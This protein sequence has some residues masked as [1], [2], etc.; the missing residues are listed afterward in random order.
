MVELLLLLIYIINI[1]HLGS[2]LPLTSS[3]FITSRKFQI[4]AYLGKTNATSSRASLPQRQ[5]DREGGGSGETWMIDQSF[6]T[7]SSSTTEGFWGEKS[8]DLCWRS[9]CLDAGLGQGFY[10]NSSFLLQH[11]AVPGGTERLSAPAGPGISSSGWPWW[12]WDARV[13]SSACRHGDKQRTI[14][15][16][17]PP[18]RGSLLLG[19]WLR[20]LCRRQI[21]FL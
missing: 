9:G 11:R 12:Q 20:C 5:Q 8:P 4:L 15:R 2:P 10:P 6:R 21:C 18:K 16:G 3:D 7:T 19:C 1:S 13:S 17:D 14:R